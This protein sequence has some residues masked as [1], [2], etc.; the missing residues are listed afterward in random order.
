MTSIHFKYVSLIFGS[1]LLFAACVSLFFIFFTT[2]S[3]QVTY[4]FVVARVPYGQETKLVCHKNDTCVFFEC[5]DTP[6]PGT[7]CCQNESICRW[8]ERDLVTAE[9]FTNRDVITS[10]FTNHSVTDEF[11]FVEKDGEIGLN[12]AT[13]KRF[14]LPIIL[15]ALGVICIF[16]PFCVPKKKPNSDPSLQNLV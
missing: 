6:F 4:G 11:E 5:G 3:E 13:E 12:T 9:F 15:I 14:T 8:Y 10:R 7:F 1:L 16:I 2:E